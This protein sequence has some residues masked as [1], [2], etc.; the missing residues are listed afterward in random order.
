MAILGDVPGNAV[1][2]PGCQFKASTQS[3]SGDKSVEYFRNIFAWKLILAT[4]GVAP[5]TGLTCSSFAD[6]QQKEAMIKAASHVCLVAASTKIDRSWFTRLGSMDVIQS[7]ITDRGITDRGITDDGIADTDTREFERCGFEV[8]IAPLGLS[9][10]DRPDPVLPPGP[11]VRH[12][13]AATGP[14]ATDRPPAS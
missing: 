11:A 8:R 6:L 7:F 13:G 14:Q 9:R 2:M 10:C 5:D 3:L 12:C 1:P 4:A